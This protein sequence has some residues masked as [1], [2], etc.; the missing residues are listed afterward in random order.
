[1]PVPKARAKQ[2]DLVHRV[3]DL[4]Q[5]SPS[6]V[7]LD[8]IPVSSGKTAKELYITEEEFQK[9]LAL[10]RSKRKNTLRIWTGDMNGDEEL[11][12]REMKAEVKALCATEN[13]KVALSDRH[14]LG[15]DG[16]AAFEHRRRKDRG[17]RYASR[18]LA[19]VT[20]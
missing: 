4:L 7:F 8:A 12:I 1:M 16:Q 15:N 17:K 6:V 11:R 13:T 20:E 5:I 9:R 10:S 14:P 18:K 2:A 19:G 3:A